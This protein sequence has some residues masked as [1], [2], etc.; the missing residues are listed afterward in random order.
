MTPLAWLSV[1]AFVLATGRGLRWALG[2]ARDALG[3]PVPFPAVG[4]VALAAASAV[5]ALPPLLTWRLERTLSAA[6]TSTAGTP[7]QVRCQ[8]IGAA[9]LDVDAAAGHVLERDGVMS[10]IVH[11]DRDVCRQLRSYVRKQGVQPTDAEVV[12]VHVLSHEARHVAGVRDEAAAECQAVQR[13][14]ATAVSLGAST[15]DAHQLAR[16]YWRG[17]YPRMRPEYVSAACG[18]GLALDE[19]LATTPWGPGG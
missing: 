2:P 8:R 15:Q 18:P 7:A 9:L 10:R 3:R 13:D 1:V 16:A 12:A 19:A 14:A 5:A 17:H 6:A 11:L 4:V